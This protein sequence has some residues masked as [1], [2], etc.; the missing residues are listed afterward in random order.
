M[1]KK[2][3]MNVVVPE[4][5]TIL[6][7]KGKLV[8]STFDIK[9]LREVVKGY[10]TN[11]DLNNYKK[12]YS[13]NIEDVI[14]ELTIKQRGAVLKRASQYG[15]DKVI[16]FML[17]YDIEKED[18][19]KAIE[20]ANINLNRKSGDVI[21]KIIIN[22]ARYYLELVAI[23]K[24]GHVLEDVSL[25]FKDNVVG[26]EP[27]TECYDNKGV[28]KEVEVFNNDMDEDVYDKFLS[29]FN[30]EGR[31]PYEDDIVFKFFNE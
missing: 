11:S 9:P 8:Y 29:Y 3:N 27:T 6:Y 5:G 28:I 20:L 14:D 1:S 16:K 24:S 30:I 13:G 15:H 26:S 19:N 4:E 2:L 21:K 25:F 7:R 22:D 10:E 17:K 12:L 23:G 18:I 31:F